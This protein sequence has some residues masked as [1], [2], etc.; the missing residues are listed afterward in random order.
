M[1]RERADVAPPGDGGR[2]YSGPPNRSHTR[3]PASISEGMSTR[4]ISDLSQHQ[5]GG[6]PL[7]P[8]RSGHRRVLQIPR[9]ALHNKRVSWPPRTAQGRS[10]ATSAP[11]RGIP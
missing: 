5:E 1:P 3:A 7:P 2:G 6:E 8:V 11:V 4:P 10:G 9:A